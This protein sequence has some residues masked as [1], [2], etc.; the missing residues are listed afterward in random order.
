MAATTEVTPAPAEA[1]P[2]APAAPTVKSDPARDG[3][4]AATVGGAKITRGQVVAWMNKRPGKKPIDVIDELVTLHLFGLEAKKANFPAPEGVSADDLLALGEAWA[5]ATFVTEEV[6]EAELVRWFDERRA[7]NRL[8]VADEALA[9]QLVESFK[10]A[11]VK[12]PR[13][14]IRRFGELSREHNIESKTIAPRRVLFDAAGLSETGSPAVHELVAKAAFAIANDGEIAGPFALGEGKWVIVQRVALRPKMEL[15][16]VPPHLVDRAKDG[17]RAKRAADAMKARAADVRRDVAV[18]ITEATISDLQPAVHTRRPFNKG[19]A[20]D[21]RRLRRERI[22]GREPN[23]RLDA[24]IPE[25]AEEGLR[26]ANPDEVR[27]KMGGD[28]AQ[29]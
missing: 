16:T 3:E 19:G 12:D 22:M 5:T 25:G 13:D 24:V 29:P 7:A 4:I 28:G 23:E 17:M 27:S 8:V 18:S 20:L 9:N 10:S 21:T 26:K 11:P 15:A 14:S 1:G 2:D 6:T